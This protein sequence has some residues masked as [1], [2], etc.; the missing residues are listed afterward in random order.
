MRAISPDTLPVPVLEASY[1]LGKLLAAARKAQGLSQT[2]LCGLVDIGLSTLVEI[3]H[4]PPKV[5]LAY[6]L[7][8]LEQLGLLESITRSI[9][10]LCLDRY[11][12]RFR[13]RSR[14]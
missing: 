14:K 12:T 10:A 9:S 4:G 6:W 2:E 5:Q 1:S 3:E 8:V 13:W 7:T 11:Q